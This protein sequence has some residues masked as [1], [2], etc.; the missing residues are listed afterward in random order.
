M[1]KTLE[2]RAHVGVD[3]RVAVRCAYL[4]CID[5]AIKL[6]IIDLRKL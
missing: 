1:Q 6:T 3:V 4:L 5:F 2:S